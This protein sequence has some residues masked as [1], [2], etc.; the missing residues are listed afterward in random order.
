MANNKSICMDSSFEE[1]EEDDHHNLVDQNHH[2][3]L[4]PL[5]TAFHM[6]DLSSR[7][8]HVNLQLQKKYIIAI[9]V[10]FVVIFFFSIFY[11][12]SIFYTSSFKFDSLND[13]L[14][15]SELCTINLLR[16]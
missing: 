4:S 8:H 10:V 2:K 13:Q 5:A 3:P 9:L 15:E 6:E 14:K 16:Q 12:R 1:E 11:F 7:F